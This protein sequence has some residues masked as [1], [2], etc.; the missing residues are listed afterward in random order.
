MHIG[1]NNLK[2][3]NFI[4]G[5]QLEKTM[6]EKDWELLL[7]AISR[8]LSNVYRLLKKGNQILG[9]IKRTITSRRKEI[10]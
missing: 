1:V 4:E 2:E 8:Y 3:E 5:K 9:L 10:I 6:E 7:A